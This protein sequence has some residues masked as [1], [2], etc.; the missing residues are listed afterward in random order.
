M[1]FLLNHTDH[2]TRYALGIADHLWPALLLLVIGYWV[3]KSL[4]KG[5]LKLLQKKLDPAAAQFVSQMLHAVLLAFLFISV[6]GQLGVNTTSLIAA[7][8]ALGLAVGLALKDSLQN[9]ASGLLLVA[10]H[11]FNKG[12][13]IEGAGTAG[14]VEK[15]TL[16][17]TYLKTPD[18]KRVMVPNSSLTGSNLVNFSAEPQRRLDIVVSVS[19]ED[20]VRQVKQLLLD[21]IAQEER[22]LD[23]PAP[24]V[25]VF[26]FA[27]SSV[28]FTMRMWVKTEDF[29]AVRWAMMEKIKIAF[30]EA[31]IT[32]PYPQ[33]DLHVHTSPVALS[34]SIAQAD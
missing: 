6:L 19:Y 7:L 21:L 2:I 30:D 1:D 26:D 32:I 23:E 10:L 18:N 14:S 25:A 9:L 31:G 12:D 4:K 33:R 15:L 27:D 29:W 11:P 17:H 8:G 13:Y 20:D 24:L 34:D 5:A 16:L 28:D 3:I 22:T